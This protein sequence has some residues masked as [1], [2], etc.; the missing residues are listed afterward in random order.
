M[1]NEEY[2]RKFSLLEKEA[3]KLEFYMELEDPR[4]G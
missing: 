1:G 4:V 3:D 2:S